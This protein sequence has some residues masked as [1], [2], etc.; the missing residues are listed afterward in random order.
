MSMELNSIIERKRQ[1]IQCGKGETRRFSDRCFSIEQGI[2]E[3][4]HGKV[5]LSNQT[6]AEHKFAWQ[7]YI[8]YVVAPRELW[9]GLPFSG[10]GSS[11]A[12]N[13]DAIK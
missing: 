12:P 4:S 5:S 8:Q 13:P 11:H 9:G 7:T 2:G 3:K 10:R 1:S 6:N